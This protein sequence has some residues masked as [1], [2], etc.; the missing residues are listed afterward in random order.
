VKHQ[1]F[2][3]A[4][5]KEMSIHVGVVV[6]AT[7]VNFINVLSGPFLYKSLLAAFL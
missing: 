1:A 2:I 5:N 4:Q 6:V 7:G 3:S